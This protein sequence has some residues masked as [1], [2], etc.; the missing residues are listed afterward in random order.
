MKVVE[1]ENQTDKQTYENSLAWNLLP[2][3]STVKHPADPST[4]WWTELSDLLFYKHIRI[5]LIKCLGSTLRG[6][7]F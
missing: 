1:S 7:S 3:G 2:R 6:F 5:F 4:Q